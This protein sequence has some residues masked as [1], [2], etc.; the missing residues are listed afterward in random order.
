[1]RREVRYKP[2][3]IQRL[4]TMP[5]SWFKFVVDTMGDWDEIVKDFL[6]IIDREQIILMPQGA[7]QKELNQ[8]RAWVAD[9]AAHKGVRF[10][11]RLHVTVW[12]KRTGV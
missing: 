2:K 5:N 4:S 8:K 12:D 11:D 6:P 1:M 9:L 7:T 3:L 10:S